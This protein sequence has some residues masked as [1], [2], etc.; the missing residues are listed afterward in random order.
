MYYKNLCTPLLKE[1]KFSINRNNPVI[2]RINS[3]ILINKIILLNNIKPEI[4]LIISIMLETTSTA[5]L[6]KTI[7]N[8]FWF[9]PVYFGY[10]ISF[11]LFPKSLTKFSLSYAYTLWCAIGIIFT[12][13]IDKFIYKQII[14]YKQ[15]IGIVFII[16]GIYISN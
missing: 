10:A 5:L 3:N 12:T 2:N 1:I 9:I 6:K 13:I 14:L 4:F 15:L 7:K 11:Y 16:S 8:K